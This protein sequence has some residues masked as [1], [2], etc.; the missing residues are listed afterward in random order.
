[1]T[2][3]LEE[4]AVAATLALIMRL[5]AENAELRAIIAESHNRLEELRAQLGTRRD[6]GPL[7][8]SADEL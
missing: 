8:V 5:R 7:Y 2:V 6:S 4:G 1:M 3:V